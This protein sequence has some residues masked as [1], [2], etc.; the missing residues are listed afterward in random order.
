VFPEHSEKNFPERSEK[1]VVLPSKARI[2]SVAILSSEAS[3]NVERSENKSPEH[4]EHSSGRKG[5]RMRNERTILQA[6]ARKPRR[7]THSSN[8]ARETPGQ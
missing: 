8:D 7:R 4:S 5:R 1:N 2:R 3:I 6:P